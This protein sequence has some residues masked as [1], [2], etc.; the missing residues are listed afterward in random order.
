M[1]DI[2]IERIARDN[3]IPSLVEQVEGML[4][5]ISLEVQRLA[6]R[7]PE[8][9]ALDAWLQQ[10]RDRFWERQFQMIDDPNRFWIRMA[11]PGAAGRRFRALISE[12]AIEVRDEAGALVRR[13]PFREQIDA[14]TVS[15]ILD[16]GYLL[17]TGANVPAQRAADPAPGRRRPNE[18]SV[19]SSRLARTA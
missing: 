5:D 9:A 19:W 3:G 12:H 2:V 17:V 4:N 14:R 1:R 6:D 11:I 10:V 8:T 16:G 13:V 18:K 15:A 7:K